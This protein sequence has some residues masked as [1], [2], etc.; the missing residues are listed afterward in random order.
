MREILKNIKIPV[1]TIGNYAIFMSKSE[2]EVWD[3]Y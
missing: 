1:I 3:L 2:I